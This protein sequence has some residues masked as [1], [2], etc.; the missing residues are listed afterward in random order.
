MVLYGKL[1]TWLINKTPSY[2]PCFLNLFLKM[3]LLKTSFLL[4]QDLN[5][6]LFYLKCPNT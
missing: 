1:V 6:V 5:Q 4:N 2:R 3:H